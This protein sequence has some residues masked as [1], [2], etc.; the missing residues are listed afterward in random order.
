MAMAFCSCPCLLCR[1]DGA[2]MANG[3]SE[4]PRGASKNLKN[5]F[6]FGEQANPGNAE[7]R[8]LYTPRILTAAVRPQPEVGHITPAAG[9][10][11]LLYQKH[12]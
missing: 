8:L 11:C 7:V 4:H 3:L 12:P 1:H 10:E 5:F 6:Q 9:A 2:G